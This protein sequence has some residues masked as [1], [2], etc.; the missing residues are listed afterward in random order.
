MRVR[1]V[2]VIAFLVVAGAACG[3]SSSK[4]S[5][6]TSAAAS[7]SNSTTASTS[8]S[9]PYGGNPA[10]ATTVAP[11][12]TA[13]LVTVHGDNLVSAKGF[14]LYAF[15]PDTATTSACATGCDSVWPPVAVAG[16]LPTMSGLTFTTLTRSDGTKQLVVNGHPVYTYSG[17]TK[18]GQ[19][20]GQGI[21]GKWY[22][23]SDE[24]QPD[25]S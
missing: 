13:A 4:A 11:A 9:N 19:E 12:T 7:S 23:V 15:S 3:S 5:N 8:A 17:D 20:N 14:T 16:A 22:Y 6:T 25:K 2:G 10:P 1:H 18:A 24:G 21:G